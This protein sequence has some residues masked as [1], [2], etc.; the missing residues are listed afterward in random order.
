[1]FVAMPMLDLVYDMDTIRIKAYISAATCKIT[2]WYF[3]QYD[4]RELHFA[5]SYSYLSINISKNV[6]AVYEVDIVNWVKRTITCSNDNTQQIDNFRQTKRITFKPGS[7]LFR[8]LNPSRDSI[9]SDPLLHN[10]PSQN[11]SC[12]EKKKCHQHF[13]PG[14]AKQT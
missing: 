3:L 9:F 2:L 12:H 14:R 13:R 4:V 5:C 11:K 8:G 6:L 10:S 7:E 1:M